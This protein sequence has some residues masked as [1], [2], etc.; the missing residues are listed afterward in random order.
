[1]STSPSRSRRM[2]RRCRN[3]T[4]FFGILMSHLPL[5]R[6]LDLMNHPSMRRGPSRLRLPHSQSRSLNSP[7]PSQSLCR[8][9]HLLACLFLSSLHILTFAP[10]PDHLSRLQLSPFSIPSFH[11]SYSFNIIRIAHSLGFCETPSNLRPTPPDT[12]AYSW[13]KQES[14]RIWFPRPAR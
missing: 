13:S 12:P 2:R 14:H 1:M 7:W 8:D 9:M 3:C 4:N 11:L 6:R 10:S 5:Q